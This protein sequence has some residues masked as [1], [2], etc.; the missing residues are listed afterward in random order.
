MYLRLQAPE[1]TGSDG[2]KIDLSKSFKVS[3]YAE[4]YGYQDSDIATQNVDVRGLKGDVNGDGEV[5]AQDA[6]LILQKVAGKIE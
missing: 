4:K 1:S 5:T 2:K 6:S 3:V